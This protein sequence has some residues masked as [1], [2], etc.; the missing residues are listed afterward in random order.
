MTS[1]M[2]RQEPVANRPEQNDIVGG[3][4]ARTKVDVIQQQVS[5]CQ[6]IFERR[7]ETL[8]HNSFDRNRENEN[9]VDET[10]RNPFRPNQASLRSYSRSPGGKSLQIWYTDISG[11][12]FPKSNSATD[13]TEASNGT[14]LNPESS[15][16]RS[17]QSDSGFESGRN[18]MDE[19]DVFD[20][21]GDDDVEDTDGPPLAPASP[22]M[23][24]ELS[25]DMVCSRFDSR[26]REMA[27]RQYSSETNS[28]SHR[29]SLVSLDSW[30]DAT[31]GPSNSKK[32]SSMTSHTYTGNHKSID[33]DKISEE[34][35][36]SEDNTPTSHWAGLDVDKKDVSL[37]SD[38]IRS[39][40]S[41]SEVAP[42]ETPRSKTD[43][44]D[45][46]VRDQQLRSDEV[47]SLMTW[48]NIPEASNV[49]TINANQ[50]DFLQKSHTQGAGSEK[51]G[52]KSKLNFKD[53]LV[54]TFSPTPKRSTP[55]VMPSIP[56]SMTQSL[57]GPD[58]IRNIREPQLQGNDFHYVGLDKVQGGGKFFTIP[59]SANGIQL[60][61]NYGQV[62]Q[63]E[64]LKT[65]MMS[66]WNNVKYGK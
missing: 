29:P 5:S 37:K 9:I 22:E 44:R 49:N 6:E 32:Q 53:R 19:M 28:K 15:K 25:L 54:A 20:C 47:H 41:W 42:L 46:S 58:E 45:R 51:S 36:C 38:K 60:P 65:K 50:D 18:F 43:T 39:F 17:L 12:T 21:D 24:Q 33:C 3:E 10:E 11:G 56:K 8:T 34:K 61:I 63:S 52:A 14:G 66:V 55:N 30:S 62:D 26:R 4:T 48:S 27:E 31:I 59:L 2:K 57:V 23:E 16:L 1:Q 40:N 13:I 7:G 35:H 64:K